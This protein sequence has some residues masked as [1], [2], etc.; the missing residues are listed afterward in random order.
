MAPPSS[1]GV[2][3]LPKEGF[4]KATEHAQDLGSLFDSMTLGL[5]R[6]LR[7]VTTLGAG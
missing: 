1:F 5:V 6:V 4:A 3:L 2:N 7:E